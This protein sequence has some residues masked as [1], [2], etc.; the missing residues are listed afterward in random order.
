MHYYT[1]YK[2]FQVLSQFTSDAGKACLADYFSV[3]KDVYPV[4][5]LDY[6]SEGLLIL[7]NDKSLNQRLLHPQFKHQRTYWAQVEGTPSAEALL[8]LQQGVWISVDGK[9]YKTLAAAAALLSPIPEI[10][11]RNPPIR[12]RKS[13]PD[14]WIELQ[15]HEGKNRQVRKMTAA[16]GYPT[17]RLIRVAIERLT[18][19]KLAPGEIK[20]WKQ[21]EIYQLLFRK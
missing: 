5:R 19:E 16:V 8:A 6:D 20:P 9:K 2:P 3:P 17:L 4:G 7:T 21:N 13:V 1:I 10:P 15:L 12:F 14:C 11:E 18:L